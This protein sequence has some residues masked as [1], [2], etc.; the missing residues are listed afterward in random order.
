MTVPQARAAT[1][2]LETL[3]PRLASWATTIDAERW[4]QLAFLQKA[5]ERGSWR[6]EEEPILAEN[7]DSPIVKMRRRLTSRRVVAANIHR[8]A[9][10]AIADLEKDCRPG[11]LEAP[12]DVDLIAARSW[13][14][15]N[16]RFAQAYSKT[17]FDLL[18]LR[19]ALQSYKVEHGIYPTQLTRLEGSHVE[20]VPTDDFS[21]GQPYHYQ[22][23]GETYRLWSVGPNAVDDGGTAISFPAW[24]GPTADNVFPRVYSDS[25]GDIVAGENC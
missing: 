6:E 9:D 14:Y 13:I 16:A 4:W 18:I 22:L 19:F 8:M 7:E 21:G 15:G 1:S 12:T 20:R 17:Q 24:S 25:K 2:R 23:N 5:F 3:Q 11:Q 10:Y